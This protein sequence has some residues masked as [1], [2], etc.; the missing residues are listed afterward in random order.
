[1]PDGRGG[2]EFNAWT[3]EGFG[4]LKL[5]MP[6]EKVEEILG[7]GFLRGDEFE[8]AATGDWVRRMLWDE[9]GIDV[10]VGS[11]EQGGPKI[12]RSITIKEPCDFKTVQGLG[13]GSPMEQ[14]KEV[15]GQWEDVEDGRREMPEDFVVGSI[16]GG[17]IFSFQDGK[18]SEMFLGA[19]AE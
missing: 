8:Q 13:I 3:D 6:V 19:A 18:V 2:P 10:W 4:E 17:L 1:M 11:L 12:V 5:D 15:Y 7:G 9:K 14:V 16:Y